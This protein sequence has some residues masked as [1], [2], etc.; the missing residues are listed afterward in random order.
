MRKVI[1]LIMIA[2]MLSGCIMSKGFV[3]YEK[4]KVVAVDDAREGAKLL[5]QAWDLRSGAL[6]EALKPYASQVPADVALAFKDLDALSA[7][8][9]A[10]NGL[11]DYDYGRAIGLIFRMKSSVIGELLHAYAPSVLKY[12]PVAP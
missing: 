1:I 6:Q 12:L 8:N 9:K 2:G 5:F 3:A 11:S 7:K 4:Q 10:D